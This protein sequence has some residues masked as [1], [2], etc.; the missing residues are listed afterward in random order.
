MI[1]SV[2]AFLS[3][4]S[5]P[6]ECSN[7]IDLTGLVY[8][9]HDFEANT[10]YCFQT[11]GSIFVDAK[12]VTIT[13]YED[14]TKKIEPKAG[15]AA[16]F[17]N[18]NLIS[19]YYYFVLESTSPITNATIYGSLEI[20]TNQIVYISTKS[21]F[22]QN[23]LSKNLKNAT[24]FLIGTH[25]NSKL[26]IET[27]DHSTAKYRSYTDVNKEAKDYTN[28]KKDDDNTQQKDN[29]T[30]IEVIGEATKAKQEVQVSLEPIG[31]G[32]GD[33][34]DDDDDDHDDARRLLEFTNEIHGAIR[35]TE[36]G[37]LTSTDFQSNPVNIPSGIDGLTFGNATPLGGGAIAGIVIFCIILVILAFVLYCFC[38]RKK[39]SKDVSRFVDQMDEKYESFNDME[40]IAD[41][42]ME[43]E[44]TN[45]YPSP[46]PMHS[47]TKVEVES[48][49][50]H[51]PEQMKHESVDA[52]PTTNP[53]A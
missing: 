16:I 39:G 36:N 1:L 4:S 7:I 40:T 42:G 51:T 52:D 44:D 11:Q 5:A 53:Y 22:K 24:M 27:D 13:G 45:Y 32:H 35:V 17:A 2:F 33:D 28:I 20:P 14:S 25:E 43:L 10:K 29:F 23:I 47:D 31:S 8:L 19:H 18:P 6:A 30:L 34:D 48:V 41:D 49:P 21:R 9:T 46:P 15:V 50:T 12:D 38:C 26:E 3:A 37:V